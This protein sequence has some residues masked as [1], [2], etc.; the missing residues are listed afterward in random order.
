MAAAFAAELPTGNLNLAV[1]AVVVDSRDALEPDLN[2]DGD[3]CD[4][5]APPEPEPGMGIVL[6]YCDGDD[7]AG[8]EGFLGTNGECLP[9]PVTGGD[10]ATAE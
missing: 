2:G 4:T 5:L 1:A 3:G 8:V 6:I 9:V 7:G 10:A